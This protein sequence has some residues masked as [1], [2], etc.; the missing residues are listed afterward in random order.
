MNK[1]LGSL[2]GSELAE[3]LLRLQLT[4]AGERELVLMVLR[5]QFLAFGRYFGKIEILGGLLLFKR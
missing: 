5:E 1:F 3:W 4:L 2:V